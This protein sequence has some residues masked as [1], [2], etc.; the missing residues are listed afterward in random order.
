MKWNEESCRSVLAVDF[1]DFLITSSL[2]AIWPSALLRSVPFPPRLSRGTQIP[3]DVLQGC[4][5]AFK[6]R[7]RPSFVCTQYSVTISK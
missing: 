2:W 5:A 7:N 3:E 4:L 6:S 1:T